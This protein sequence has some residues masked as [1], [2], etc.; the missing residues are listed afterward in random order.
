MKYYHSALESQ[1]LQ[2]FDV[3][4]KNEAKGDRFKLVRCDL[5]KSGLP[6][7]MAE[8]DAFYSDPPWLP[9]FKTFNDRA[10][11]ADKRTYAEFGEM[12]GDEILAAMKP[13]YLTLGK[14]LLRH[15]P[16]PDGTT[17]YK[18]NGG[19][20]ILAWWFDEGEG[21]VD[22][23]DDVTI[24]LAGKYE[25]LGD[26]FCGYGESLR[27]FLSHGGHSVV[28]SDFDGKCI[29]VAADLFEGKTP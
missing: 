24:Y 18:L 1:N 29:A 25:I 23:H 8:C 5:L 17:P 3:K 19:D 28:G 27:N 16:E 14:S 20:A 10:G 6:P 4:P 7:V 12:L 2:I 15:L 26:F 13:T 22:F 21:P 11:V 9:G